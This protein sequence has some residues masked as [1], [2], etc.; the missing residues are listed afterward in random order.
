MTMR[1]FFQINAIYG[2]CLEN[3]K[4]YR[5]VKLISSREFAQKWAN[6]SK[7]RSFTKIDND[8]VCI[9]VIKERI[10]LCKPIYAGMV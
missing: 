6:K 3:V 4:N 1:L 8:L 2:K 5:N 7:F 9:D 10:K